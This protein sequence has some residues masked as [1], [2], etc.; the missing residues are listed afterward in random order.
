[1]NIRVVVLTVA[2][3][4][5][6]S[7]CV[8]QANKA[9]TDSSACDAP[10][11]I[12]SPAPA[13]QKSNLP[14]QPDQTADLPSVVQTVEKA[15]ECYQALSREKDPLQPKGLPKLASA[16]LDFKT[17][18]SKTVGFTFSVFVFKIGASGEKDI[19]NDISFTYA[20][21]PK[22]LPKGEGFVKKGPAPLYEELVKAVAAAASAAQ[23]QSA[24][25]GLPLNKVSVMV[26]YGIKFDG[27]V[28]INVPVQLVTIGGN[29]D[30]NK[31]NTQT[32]TLTFGPQ[33][34]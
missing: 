21:K 19:T 32:I 12:T 18:T 3:L 8:A 27:N 22:T 1:M 9:A 24:L 29:G 6:G 17:T 20:P 2:A 15:L 7:T 10:M 14:K 4:A 28:S 5:A 25:L 33:P 34:L 13:Y 11:P 16:M 31:N 23:A 30:Y 26:S